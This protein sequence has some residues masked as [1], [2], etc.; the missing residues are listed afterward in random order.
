[1][2]FLGFYFFITAISYAIAGFGGGSTYNALLMLVDTD[3]RLVPFISLTCN[4]LVVSSGVWHFQREGHI[5]AGRVLPWTCFSIPAALIGGMIPVSEKFFMVIL[6]IALSL[7]SVRMLWPKNTTT[8]LIFE[9][10]A[11]IFPPV[12]GTALGFLAGI[13]GIGGGIF[14]AP[15]LYFIGWGHAK[16]ISG[17]CSAFIFLNS[18]AGLIGQGVKSGNNDIL[19]QVHSYWPLIPAVI[20]G[21]QIGSWI[22]A[23]RISQTVVGNVTAILVLYV[24]VRLLVKSLGG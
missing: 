21:G 20:I 19:L 6:G 4:I 7:S 1:M 10:Y 24:A 9:R 11:M 2:I 23:S 16:Q 18:L 12:L 8:R 14:L 3:Y 17:A 22:G 5:D 15:A 13:T